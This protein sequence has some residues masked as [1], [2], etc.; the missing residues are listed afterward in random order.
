M[1]GSGP[2]ANTWFLGLTR[3]NILNGITIN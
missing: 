2:L 3:V 1:W